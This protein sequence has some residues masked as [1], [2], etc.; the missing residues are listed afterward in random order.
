M[1][2]QITG[3][4]HVPDTRTSPTLLTIEITL[5]LPP[6]TNVTGQQNQA[7][8]NLTLHSQEC[9]K[10]TVDK[11]NRG[12]LGQ[13]REHQELDNLAAVCSVLQNRQHRYQ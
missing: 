2:V 10:S 6:P 11:Q 3:I 7:K 5:R 1:G 8:A 12:P 4:L 13:P 9:H